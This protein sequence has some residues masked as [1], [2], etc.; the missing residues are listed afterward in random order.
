MNLDSHAKSVGLAI[1]A[2]NKIAVARGIDPSSSQLTI[3]EEFVPA[4]GTWRI[5][6]GTRDFV[7]RRGGDLIVLVDKASG[8]IQQ[9]LQ[10][11]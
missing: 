2:A 4:K 1:A 9:G 11:Q 8:E 7:R 5:E 3:T 6:Y 10:G